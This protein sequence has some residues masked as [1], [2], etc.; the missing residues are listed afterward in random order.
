MRC[1]MKSGLGLSL[2]SWYRW[3]T[4]PR[5]KA[6][7]LSASSATI[8]QLHQCCYVST[9]ATPCKMRWGRPFLVSLSLCNFRVC[10]FFM[11]NVGH[12]G[13]LSVCL[14]QTIVESITEGCSVTPEFIWTA[15]I[16]NR[17]YVSVINSSIVQWSIIF[18]IWASHFNAIYIGCYWS[19]TRLNIKN[20]PQLGN[21]RHLLSRYFSKDG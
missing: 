6:G 20:I 15:L 12:L 4:S 3:P 18:T 5:V 9:T 10:C 21:N 17:S 19:P 14:G 11:L 16:V 8:H 7:D 13:R 2:R 1:T